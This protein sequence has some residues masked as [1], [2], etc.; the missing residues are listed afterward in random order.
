M[1]PEK[2]QLEF[3]MHNGQFLTTDSAGNVVPTSDPVPIDDSPE[4]WIDE[5]VQFMRNP[6]WFGV[7]R[8]MAASMFAFKKQGRTI[9][10]WLFY[11][12]SIQAAAELVFYRRNNNNRYEGYYRGSMDFSQFKHTENSAEIQIIEG[13]VMELVQANRATTYEIPI[14]VPEA[15]SVAWDGIVMYSNVSVT[16]PTDTVLGIDPPVRNARAT[17]TLNIAM[18][19]N[20]SETQYPSVIFN[21]FASFQE[22]PYNPAAQDIWADDWWFRATASTRIQFTGTLHSGMASTDLY[23]FLHIY[24]YN[25]AQT[26]TVQLYHFN[27]AGGFSQELEIPIAIDEQLEASERVWMYAQIDRSGAGETIFWGT[28]PPANRTLN[29]VYTFRQPTTTVKHLRASYVLEQLI[30][31][32]TNG[33]YGASSTLLAALGEAYDFTLTCGDAIRGLEGAVLKTSLDDF[34]KSYN[35]R[36]NIGLGNT[37]TGV[38]VE[39]KAHFFQSGVVV[40][41]GPVANA[42][43]TPYTEAMPNN[44]KVGWPNQENEVGDVNGKEEFNTTVE[45][46]T[47]ITKQAKEL[48]LVSVYRG[49]AYGAEKIRI[50]LEGKTTVDD[51]SDNDVFMINIAP[52]AFTANAVFFGEVAG[53]NQFTIFGRWQSVFVGDQIT[54]SGTASNNGTY[55]VL[56]VV[57]SVGTIVTV[58]E[59]TVAETAFNATFTGARAA[60]NRPA[61][62]AVAGITSA[63]S[64]FNL[65]LRPGLCIRAHGNY[66]RAGMHS[67]DGQYLRY[68]TTDK[69][70]NLVVTTAGQPMVEKADILIGSLVGKLF[71]PILATISVRVPVNIVTILEVNPYA[72]VQF[73]WNEQQYFGFIMKAS[74]MPSMNTEQ[75]YQLLLSTAVDPLTLIAA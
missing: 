19:L 73:E 4:G 8:S 11:N 13:G 1:Q 75:T 52:L 35:A 20:N 71:I 23:V 33:V 42:E 36:F 55:T 60:L 7:F 29:A 26:R 46:T 41:L 67:M 53:V 45:W 38:I 16:V 62:D 47:P 66:L 39:K 14:D 27:Q 63:D 2:E 57:K 21:S 37:A 72:Q 28:F 10:L 3:I 30:R 24:N 56:D 65:E 31:K 54:I 51:K 43:F 17:D 18:F 9:L 25:T 15:L 22:G 5:E 12:F 61:Y 64:I 40:N 70:A 34:F 32:I 49:D 59:T 50:N 44:V 48:D 69:N 58:Q 68:Q 74:Q 6:S